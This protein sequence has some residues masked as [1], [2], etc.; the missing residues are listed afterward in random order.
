M[1]KPNLEEGLKELESSLTTGGIMVYGTICNHDTN[2]LCEHRIKWIV[3]F[4][5]E[6]KTQDVSELRELKNKV[7]AEMAVLKHVHEEY[8]SKYSQESQSKAILVEAQMQ[9]LQSAIKI[10]EQLKSL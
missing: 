6:I 2:F 8:K 10:I 5:A 3:E 9:G 4:V 1:D 7:S